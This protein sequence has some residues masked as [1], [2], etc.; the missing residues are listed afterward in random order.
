VRH[1]TDGAGEKG[2]T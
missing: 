2:E 1:G